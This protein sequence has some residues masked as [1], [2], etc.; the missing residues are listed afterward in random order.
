MSNVK[1]TVRGAMEAEAARRFV[2]AWHRG[3]RGET[4]SERHVGFESFET[5]ARVLTSERLDVLRTV[6][7][8]PAI[9][10][11]ALADALGR[12]RESVCADV[13]ELASVGLLDTT[14]SALTVHYDRIE[15]S[16]AL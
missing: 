13:E 7:K 16:I 4:F 3:E 14:G 15:T 8:H 12:D 9:G 11:E 2:D 1:I 6:H 10:V 5:L